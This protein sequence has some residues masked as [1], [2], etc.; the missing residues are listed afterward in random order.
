MISIWEEG[1]DLSYAVSVFASD[2]AKIRE[3]AGKLMF[4]NPSKALELAESINDEELIATITKTQT[5]GEK[6]KNY[7]PMQ[8]LQALGGIASK[9]GASKVLENDVLEQIQRKELI[10]FGYAL[11]RKTVDT[12]IQI[13][14]DI[15]SK[16]VD[17]S[18][19]TVSG[20]GLS[21]VSVRLVENSKKLSVRLVEE[22]DILTTSTFS[23]P[24]L[25][26]K[27]GRKSRKEEI[28]VAYSAL[29]AR[30]VITKDTPTAILGHEIR[31]Y[32]FEDVPTS[33]RRKTGLSDET[34]RRVLRSTK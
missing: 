8:V 26:A 28:M 31:N 14:S 33:E 12:P 13:P 21:F 18:N 5:L 19:S 4:D 10:G 32:I 24:F 11:P 22:A 29:E 1:T 15:W 17:W 9:S 20:S 27:A 7:M 30:G 16:R 3:K 34:I 6:H 23:S 2:A 25:P